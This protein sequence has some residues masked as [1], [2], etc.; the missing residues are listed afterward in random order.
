MARIA[1]IEKTKCNPEKCD[2]LCVRLCPVNREDKDCIIKDKKAVIKE[3]LCTGCGICQNR[4]PFGAISIINLPEELEK[5]LIHRYGENGFLLYRLPIPK[6]GEVVGLLG[7]N[8]IGKTTALN[9]LSG[10][11]KANLGKDK[12]G[13]DDLIKMFRGTEI[14][15]Y[16]TKMKEGKIKVSYKPQ[17][18]DD[19]PKQFKGKVRNLLE[20][21]DE[22]KKMGE[23]AKE[24]E[25]D[26][27]LD[28]DIKN[29]SGGELQRIAIAATALK[30]ANVYYFDEPSSYL[31][32]KQRL[33]TARFIRKLADEGAAVMVVEHDL[34]VLDYI[35]DK[36]HLF[37]GKESGFGV[38]SQ[39]MA[40]KVGINTYLEGY[41]KSENVRFRDKKIEFSAR[42]PAKI[43]KANELTKWPNMS[44]KLDKFTL[45][46]EEG[47]VNLREVTGIIGQNA[48][49]K[50]TFV[51]MLAGIIKPDNGKV[52]MKL[53]IA[54]KP[55]YL[56]IE[57]DS[58]VSI[59][60]S[61][62]IQKYSHILIRPLE[63]EPLL[64]KKLSELSGGELQRV[65]IAL[66][67]SQDA[68]LYLLDEPSAY[69][70]VEQ[71][72]HASK[73]INEI[74]EEKGEAAAIVVDH[75]LLFIDYLSQRLLV[76]EGEPSVKGKAGK[77]LSMEEGMNKLL[78]EL[79]ITLRRDEET[80]RP[81][82]NK[83]GS[84]KDREQ[85][86]S[87]KLYYT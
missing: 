22:K 73:V 1:V 39:P 3:E 8:G 81:R 80:K 10:N 6:E 18:V 58:I 78:T 13:Y 35:A 67:L 60:L 40:S 38:V 72:L 2:W 54:Y 16:F 74:I 12:A 68:D 33:K 9:I 5:D 37:Y 51:K 76:F 47:S 29:V 32:I 19:I 84:V 48:T 87:G 50:T 71:R 55:Q 7:R 56:E 70:D 17:K 59:I 21:A 26:K 23:F 31:D 85:K 61:K 24:L 14:Q 20:K 52:D 79:N 75:D 53:K 65:A 27:V 86:K 64:L 77:P 82:I 63:I 45:E 36:I 66:C 28:N 42:A 57:E 15:G 11:V 25:I 44:K 30:K 41:L 4:C 62:A 43:K 34:I 46:A 83:E 49:G 69:L